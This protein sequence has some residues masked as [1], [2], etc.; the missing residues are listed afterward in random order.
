M[1]D[2]R[3]NP[4]A[5][6]PRPLNAEDP[7]PP[8]APRIPR[9]I[10]AIQLPNGCCH[11][12]SEHVLHP[13]RLQ[14]QP[15]PRAARSRALRLQGRRRL[16]ASRG[17]RATTRTARLP[18]ASTPGLPSAG[19][20]GRG[21]HSRPLGG[22]TT[23]SPGA[24]HVGASA[25]RLSGQ[26]RLALPHQV[27]QEHVRPVASL[28]VPR[29]S[30]VTLSSQAAGLLAAGSSL[31]HA[32]RCSLRWA[33]LL[34]SGLPAQARRPSGPL[35]AGSRRALLAAAQPPA[36]QG[37]LL[38]TLRAPL[39]S[40]TQGRCRL[41]TAIRAAAFPGVHASTGPLARGTRAQDGP[42]VTPRLLHL[43]QH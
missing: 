5:S 24:L 35:S 15:G 38:P 42:G 40:E 1:L 16:Q 39:P 43:R 3:G 33:A 30:L 21:R 4:K 14:E 19:H 11:L 32:R 25:S 20:W 22:T 18:E 26:A 34:P 12:S 7:G 17:A 28:L 6:P 27:S 41:S 8:P 36:P 10:S 23:A 37:Q 29:P 31:L 9:C 2:P 13:A